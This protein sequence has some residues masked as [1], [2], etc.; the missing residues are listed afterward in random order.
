VLI[1][2]GTGAYNVTNVPFIATRQ[3]REIRIEPAPFDLALEEHELEGGRRM[4]VN[5]FWDP[6]TMT[7]SD[8]SK[9]RGL[10]DCGSRSSHGWD[11]RRFRL[12]AREEMPECRGSIVYVTTWRAD[13]Q[14]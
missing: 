7:L 2:C 12:T 8:F 13:V 11:G 5:A 6:A 9:G 10:G 14:R 1:A 3:G 4:L